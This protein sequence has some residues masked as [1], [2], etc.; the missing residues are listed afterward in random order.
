ML[1]VEPSRA[2]NCQITVSNPSLVTG[3]QQY[4]HPNPQP[5]SATVSLMCPQPVS[6]GHLSAQKWWHATKM[7]ENVYVEYRSL[8]YLRCR[9]VVRLLIKYSTDRQVRCLWEK[10]EWQLT[11][12][13]GWETALSFTAYPVGEL[14]MAAGQPLLSL[15][16]CPI[17]RISEKH[18][19]GGPQGTGEAPVCYS[20]C[21][22]LCT[23]SSSTDTAGED[24]RAQNTVCFPEQIMW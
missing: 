8:Y 5:W 1:A 3:L 12:I 7:N 16:S 10:K 19:Q 15:F 11:V 14:L 13:S 23:T 18:N 4:T 17:H 24:Q 6:H 22:I 9:F 20:H 21:L 2:S